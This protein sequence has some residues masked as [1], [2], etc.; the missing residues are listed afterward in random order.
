MNSRISL[1]P[2]FENSE[3]LRALL[4]RSWYILSC[5]TQKDFLR[6]SGISQDKQ[7]PGGATAVVASTGAGA[8]VVAVVEE[9][10]PAP[11]VVAEVP[12]V[13]PS[14]T[15]PGCPRLA[16]AEKAPGVAPGSAPAPAGISVK[17]SAASPPAV[18][19]APLPDD[20]S[21][22]ALQN[23]SECCLRLLGCNSPAH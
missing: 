17:P 16:A 7:V 21:S 5:S 22:G 4:L 2:A 9:E 14:V 8:G 6:R 10:L 12:G 15:G 1:A 20:R 18:A 11:V 19:T 3:C 13:E 23:K